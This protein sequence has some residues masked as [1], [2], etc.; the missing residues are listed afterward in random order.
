MSE[1][2]PSL[3]RRLSSLASFRSPKRK[4]TV[5]SQRVLERT[6]STMMRAQPVYE[7]SKKKTICNF[8]L[9]RWHGIFVFSAIS[10][11]IGCLLQL[12][13]PPPFGMRMTSSEVAEIGIAPDGCA[14][15][16]DRCICPR[17]TICATD[18]VSMA[19]LALARCSAFFDYP[20]YMMMFLSK[21]QNINNILRRTVLREF[22]D[23]AVMHHLHVL[24]H[25]RG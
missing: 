22:I 9:H 24:F 19:L 13:L 3:T 16:L 6:L 17:E 11:L 7:T 23:F 1:S 12:L 15:G 21:A 2:K 25:N 14:D 20:L 8:T 5:A 4:S 10:L 18:R